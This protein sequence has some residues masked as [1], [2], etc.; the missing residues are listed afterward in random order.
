MKV[1]LGS[2][3]KKSKRAVEKSI[4]DSSWF[5]V[6]AL[7]LVTLL[8]IAIPAG[9]TDSFDNETIAAADNTSS[10][11]ASA[12]PT[13]LTATPPATV[14]PDPETII[15]TNTGSPDESANT[16]AFTAEPTI[17]PTETSGKLSNPTTS[18]NE[19]L[20]ITDVNIGDA[21][22]EPTITSKPAV[23]E[24]SPNSQGAEPGPGGPAPVAA[25]SSAP[26]SVPAL[27]EVEFTDLSTGSPTS[28]A[29]FSAM[30]CI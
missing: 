2:V 11:D 23:A 19:T 8:L 9:A 26:T 14:Q 22:V 5:Q 12:N 29:W 28:R 20:T 6:L 10:M 17:A 24:T 1:D 7:I 30:R 13:V 4:L 25:F 27:P 16:T 15:N 18:G 3:Q 21:T